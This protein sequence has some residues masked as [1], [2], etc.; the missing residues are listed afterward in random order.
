ML[1]WFAPKVTTM[2]ATSRPS[3]STP[4][5]LT[6][7]PYRRSAR[8]AGRRAACR[9]LSAKTASS[10]CSALNPLARRIALRSHCRPK[11]SS[12]AADDQTQDVDRQRG[13]R[14]A[15]HGDDRRERDRRRRRP[16]PGR[17][18][19]ACQPGGEHDRHRLD[20][21][22]SAGGEHR[23]E[24]ENVGAHRAGPAVVSRLEQLAGE[25]RE[26]CE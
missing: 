21:L 15:E 10:S 17:A 6:V 20:A 13:E 3:S 22:H 8:L 5:K 9:E 7:K 4:L 1:R 11:T 26:K 25:D 18:P 16:R 2:N 23:E 19:A 14:G 24:E 12:S